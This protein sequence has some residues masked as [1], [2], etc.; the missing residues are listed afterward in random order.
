MN[1]SVFK[2]LGIIGILMLSSCKTYFIPIESF[3]NQFEN[4]D[5]SDLKVVSICGAVNGSYLAN[6][7]E[8]IKCIDKKGNP[9][10]L[11]N[12]PSIEIRFTRRDKKKTILYFDRVLLYDSVIYGSQSRIIP[13]IIN[14]VP[15]NQVTE[16]EIKDGHKNYHYIDN[17]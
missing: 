10:E 1:K 14:T 9:I 12:S 15:L 3:K 11:V 6:P 16:I 4:L 7:I 8:R 2:I 5:S 17:R 13:S